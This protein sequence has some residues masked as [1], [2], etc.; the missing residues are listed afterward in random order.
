MSYT[1]KLLSLA[2]GAQLVSESIALGDRLAIRKARYELVAILR[3][4]GVEAE[5]EHML[6]LGNGRTKILGISKVSRSWWTS[7]IVE[8]PH[9]TEFW[10]EPGCTYVNW[11]FGGGVTVALGDP[12][13]DGATYVRDVRIRED[14]LLTIWPIGQTMA[15]PVVSD[16][17][18]QRFR[19]DRGS[20]I[21]K[22]LKLKQPAIDTPWKSFCKAVR[23]EAGV[24]DSSRG[25][26]DETIED[27][28]RKIMRGLNY[29]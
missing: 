7:A 29:R 16:C 6:T 4:G 23:E 2:D 26:S 10:S 5:G 13:I 27:E 9:R 18:V 14:A 20:A 22:V 12:P 25:W 1:S 3:D 28:T 8:P 17:R 24:N 15:A 21:R 19:C 11:H